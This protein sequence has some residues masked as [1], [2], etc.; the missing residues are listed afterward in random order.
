MQVIQAVW[1]GPALAYAQDLMAELRCE[2]ADLVVS[3][4]FLFGVTLGCEALGQPFCWLPVNISLFPI[5]GIPPVGP[6]LPPARTEAERAMHA[7]IGAGVVALFDA[8]LPALNS[9]RAALRLAPLVHTVDLAERPLATLLATARAFD[10]APETLPPRVR[11]VGPQLDVPGWTAPWTSPW[12]AGDT[13]PLVMVGFSTTFQNHAGVLQRV[14]DA[15]ADLPVRVLVTLGGSIG[16]QDLTPPSNA[17]V[18][19]SAPH[20]AVMAQA[21]VVVTHG[22]HG[23]VTRALIH[24]RPLLVV[25]HGRDQTDNAVRV[26]ERG[27]GLALP[28]TA[29]TD[30]LRAAMR[31]L[32]DEPG[33]T[34]AAR[35]L[36][37]A[38]AHE[39]ACSPVVETLEGLAALSIPVDRCA[40]A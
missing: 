8:A 27:A 24:R 29:S 2:P 39:A 31:R 32:L 35:D 14:M 33:F 25:P 3:S 23:T 16:A 28:P 17:R 36:G 37:D 15:A 6:G 12:P 22:G 11:Y 13:R 1:A 40:A 10:F 4:E 26:T 21:A 18:V 9:A 30:E 7:E 5:P 34:D 20:D 38:V 19:A